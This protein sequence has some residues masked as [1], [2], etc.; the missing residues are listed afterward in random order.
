[1]SEFGVRLISLL[2]LVGLFT[3]MLLSLYY[4]FLGCYYMF[5]Q[6]EGGFFCNLLIHQ[7]M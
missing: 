1:M 7:G 6:I 4:M 2:L 5:K 3:S